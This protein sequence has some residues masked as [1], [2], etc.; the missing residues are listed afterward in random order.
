MIRE[1]KQ[2]IL[3]FYILKGAVNI[4]ANL[5]GPFCYLPSLFNAHTLLANG[6]LTQM[7]LQKAKFDHCF[8]N[9]ESHTYFT[10]ATN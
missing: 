7:F 8:V 4:P 9:V 5:F 6:R 3:N 10:L 2:H 1:L